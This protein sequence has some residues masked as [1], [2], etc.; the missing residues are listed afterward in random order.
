M[1]CPNGVKM[2]KIHKMA[3]CPDDFSA[4]KTSPRVHGNFL[5]EQG[6][7]GKNTTKG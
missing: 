2:I 4:M 3:K 7:V 1:F 6:T 5:K